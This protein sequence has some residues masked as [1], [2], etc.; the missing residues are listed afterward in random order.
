MSDCLELSAQLIRAVDNGIRS[1]CEDAGIGA[2]TRGLI[3]FQINAEQESNHAGALVQSLVRQR[4]VLPSSN[5]SHALSNQV[6]HHGNG[7]LHA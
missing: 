6:L 7:R 4:P 1:V 5:P 2:H 3:G